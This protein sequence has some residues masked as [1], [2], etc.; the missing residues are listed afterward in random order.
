[1]KTRRYSDAAIQQLQA[2]SRMDGYASGRAET[3]KRLNEARA[4]SIRAVAD[5]GARLAK[6]NASLT[7]SLS[8]IFDTLK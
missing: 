5:A 8:R 7:Y 1:M 2:M 3:E 6:A 4:V